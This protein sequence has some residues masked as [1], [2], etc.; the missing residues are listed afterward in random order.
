MMIRAI[1]ALSLLICTAFASPSYPQAFTTNVWNGRLTQT[2]GSFLGGGEGSGEYALVNNINMT[3]GDMG[4]GDNIS[5]PVNI[6]CMNV[7]GF[8]TYGCDGIPINH[9]GWATG[10]YFLPTQANR[11][12]GY[13]VD[14]IGGAG[15]QIDFTNAGGTFTTSGC[16]GTSGN[17]V[18]GQG[19]I[20]A[21]TGQ[22]TGCT[23]TITSPNCVSACWLIITAVDS[24]TPLMQLRLYHVNDTTAMGLCSLG[25]TSASILLMQNCFIPQFLNAASN[26]GVFRDLYKSNALFSNV[27]LWAERTPLPWITYGG[28]ANYGANYFPAAMVTTNAPVLVSGIS[29]TL[30]APNFCPSGVLANC[31]K[32]HI[33]VLPTSAIAPVTATANGAVSTVT[34]PPATY[35]TPTTCTINLNSVPAS[36]VPGMTIGDSSATNAVQPSGVT[37]LSVGAS[38]VTLACVRGCILGGISNGDTLAFSQM[39]N[40]N[41]LGYIPLADTSGVNMGNQ[42]PFTAQLY[43]HWSTLTYDAGLNVF[44]VAS[45]SNANFGISG[46]WPP[47]LEIALANKIGA[48]PWY[49]AG[50]Y[51]MDS[52]TNFTGQLAKLNYSYLYASLIPREEG[53]N[54]AWNNNDLCTKYAYAKQY[55]KSGVDFDVNSW[56]GQAMLSIGEAWSSQYGFTQTTPATTRALKYQVVVSMDTQSN[57]PTKGGNGQ[58]NRVSPGA[59]WITGIGI[60]GYWATS[61]AGTLNEVGLAYAY[62]QSPSSALI[63]TFLN[64][65]SPAVSPAC[66]VNAT[67]NNSNLY[68]LKNVIFPEWANYVSSYVNA[69][70]P[71]VLTQY[72]GGGGLGSFNTQTQEATISAFTPGTATVLTIGSN[73]YN[74]ICN[75]ASLCS[76]SAPTGTISGTGCPALDGKD[77]A[78]QSAT[79]T[80]IT[81]NLNSTGCTTSSTGIIVYDGAGGGSGY[82][83]AFEQATITDPTA[84]NSQACEIANLNSFF[85]AGAAASP[86]PITTTFPAEFDLS[87]TTPFAKIYPN[88]FNTTGIPFIAAIQ[89]YQAAAGTGPTI[90][91]P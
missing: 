5:G 41:G 28:G 24:T 84:I 11:S 23:V 30:S 7:N 91:A 79:T 89:A 39:F 67:G 45:Q 22:P 82:M 21:T 31:D 17:K 60:T 12:G 37:V 56:Y 20:S 61:C 47:E 87:D 83:V 46:G 48:H 65:T 52:F 78:I 43:A 16:V 33:I 2:T 36:I 6:S 42:F 13:I 64:D 76:G 57:V 72:E 50:C 8:P 1:L 69:G 10:S 27:A 85:A 51:A 32:Q 35:P 3:V 34:C 18:T 71:F 4:Y 15:T 25:L 73:A 90:C 40:V 81:V 88:V 14:W 19:T 54:E 58:D 29:Y 80:T 44:M 59:N 70:Y 49:V 26:F 62:K 68:N 55:L 63:G 74:Y 66:G 77:P 38:S 53:P 86:V 75:T 9:S